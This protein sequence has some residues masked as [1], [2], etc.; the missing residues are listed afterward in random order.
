M[1]QKFHVTGMTCSACSAKVERSVKKL[2][3]VEAVNVNL[4][5]NSMTVDF[6][7]G[8]VTADQIAETVTR[9]GMRLSLWK[10]SAEKIG[11]FQRSSGSFHAGGN[12]KDAQ[13]SDRFLCVFDSADVCIHGTYDEIA[14][15][16]LVPWK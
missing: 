1:H 16:G 11:G 14:S 10:K 8:A 6:Q 4:L 3:G 13:P 9:A 5:S 7:E 12:E 2:E 15:S